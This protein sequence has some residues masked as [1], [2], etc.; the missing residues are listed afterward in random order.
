MTYVETF[1]WGRAPPFGMA[2]LCDVP[3]R[4]Q[5]KSFFIFILATVINDASITRPTAT[6]LSVVN[7][8]A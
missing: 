8:F 4:E 2:V 1:Q 3:G 6:G 5:I 7:Y